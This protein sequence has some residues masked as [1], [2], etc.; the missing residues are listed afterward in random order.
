MATARITGVGL[1]APGDPISNTEVAELAGVEIDAEKLEEKLGIRHRHIAHLRDLDETT[2]DFAERAAREAIEDAGIDPREIGL[3]VVGTDTPEYISPSTAVLIQGRIQGG[4][5]AA[6]SF[7]VGTSCAGF[8]TSLDVASRMLG[9]NPSLRYAVVVGVYNMPRY[10]R[11]GDAFGYSIFADGGAAVVLERSDDGVGYEDGEF[12][13]DGTQWDY[14]GVYAGGTRRP[15]TKEVLESEQYGLE[16][17]QRLPGDRNIKLWPPLVRTLLERN[18]L[19]VEDVDHII[20]TQINLSVI[21]EVMGILSLPME[22]TTTIMDRYGYTGSGCVPMALY[23]ALKEGRV[24]QGD[25]MVFVASGAGL[26]V[27]ANLLTL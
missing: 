1:Y 19:G 13:T 5:H 20:F 16:L 25:R 12:I 6:A 9:S 17:L 18:N 15:V 10:V 27:G 11:H 21:K 8:V 2:A 4:Q 14:V 3:F 23:H 7:D 26:S 22:R 24:K